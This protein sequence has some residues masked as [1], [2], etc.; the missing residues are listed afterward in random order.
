M[1]DGEEFCQFR[2]VQ[3][4]TSQLASFGC[5][6]IAV[7]THSPNGSFRQLCVLRPRRRMAAETS[8]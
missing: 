6:G 5:E 2:H 8:R 7:D 3:F 4:G 1:G